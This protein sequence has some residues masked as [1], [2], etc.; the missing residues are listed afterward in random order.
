[1]AGPLGDEQL[2]P[3]VL[4]NPPPLEDR[5]GQDVGVADHGL[6]EAAVRCG[7][8]RPQMCDDRSRLDARYFGCA[9]LLRGEVI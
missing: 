2:A 4:L 1:M 8:G 3:V 6:I 5:L 9:G 7:G